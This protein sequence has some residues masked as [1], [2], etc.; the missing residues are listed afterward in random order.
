MML[1]AT[2][3]PV[4][5]NLLLVSSLPKR[6]CPDNPD[7]GSSSSSPSCKDDTDAD[8]AAAGRAS[9]DNAG[10]S[11]TGIAP[12]CVDDDDKYKIPSCR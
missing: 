1:L 7:D 2:S 11:T 3:L 5:I 4:S 8:T 6:A 12:T 9:P 10:E